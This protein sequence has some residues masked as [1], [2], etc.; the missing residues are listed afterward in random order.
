MNFY[1]HKLASV[2]VLIILVGLTGGAGDILLYKWAKTSQLNWLLASYVA[3]F[4][5][6]TLFGLLFRMEH[7]SFGAA[8]VMATVV[9]L[10]LD[11]CW[12]LV[13]AQA[14]VSSLEVLGLVFGLIAIVLLEVG[15]T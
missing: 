15:R 4:C 8:V 9:H 12:G 5:C 10:V 13:T 3:W 7:F 14:R 2:Y 11:V 6:V 1:N